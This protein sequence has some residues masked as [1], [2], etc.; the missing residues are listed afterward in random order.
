MTEVQD[1]ILTHEG[2]QKEI[3][4]FIHEYMMAQ[5]QVTAKLR[6]KIPFYYRK[7]WI[8]YLNPRKDNSIEFCFIRGRE[9]SNEQGIIEAK[10]RKMIKSIN[11]T[12]LKDL[13]Q[14]PLFEVIQEA[15]LLDDTVPFTINKK[16]R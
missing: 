2:N 6:Y 15:L 4:L 5:P 3:M 14:E 8:C 1:F 13:P 10:G 11:L 12:N 7:T 16:T 9:L